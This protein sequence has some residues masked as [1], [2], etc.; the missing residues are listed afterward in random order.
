MG[1]RWD[2]PCKCQMAFFLFSHLREAKMFRI[3]NLRRFSS[4]APLK[5][6]YTA[7]EARLHEKL[8]NALQATKL[9]VTDI[10]GIQ[11]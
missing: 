4:P 9:N 2:L 10:S 1:S 8:V 11:S 7:G 6:N 3:W 5:P